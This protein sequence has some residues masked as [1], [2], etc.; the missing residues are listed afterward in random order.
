MRLGLGYN[1]RTR[2]ARGSWRAIQH[3]H[4][5]QRIDDG[6]KLCVVAEL[7]VFGKHVQGDQWLFH[8][9]RQDRSISG[10]LPGL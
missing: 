1:R 4:P 10:R 6:Q 3:A 5:E 9:G 2:L 7:R 8:R